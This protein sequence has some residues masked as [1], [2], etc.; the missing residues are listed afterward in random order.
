MDSKKKK[1]KKK[2]GYRK[3]INDILAMHGNMTAKDFADMIL[4]KP[5]PGTEADKAF[6]YPEVFK[7]GPEMAYRHADEPLPKGLK[8][9]AQV[10]SPFNFSVLEIGTPDKVQFSEEDIKRAWVSPRVIL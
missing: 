9:M 7:G 3:Q 2:Y 10:S 8:L 1:K 4:L 5:I 6:K